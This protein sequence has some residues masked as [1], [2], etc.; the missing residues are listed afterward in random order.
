MTIIDSIS[1]YIKAY[2]T[3]WYVI[4]TGALVTYVF[5]N[6]IN[7]KLLMKKLGAEYPANNETDGYY[8]FQIARDLYVAKR[9]G[10]IN[11]FT[12]DRYALITDPTIP[13]FAFPLLG[14]KVVVTKDPEN[15]KAIL[16]TQFN[17]FALGQRHQQFHPV[18][19]DGI[20]TLDGEG[21]KQS[22]SMLRPQFAREQVGHVQSLEPHIQFLARHIESQKGKSFDIQE[23][24]FRFTLDASTEFLFGES[25][26]SLQT[27]E[28][29]A[30][31]PDS[32]DG[33]EEFTE[34]F[35]VVQVYLANRALLQGFYWMY[36]TADFRLRTAQVHKFANQYVKLALD[37]SPEELEKKSRDGY[38]FLY[39]LC[40][41]T[42]NHDAI[43]DQLLN[44]LIA[45]RDT[46]AGLLS[47]TYYE[48]ARNP[49]IWA[50]LKAEIYERFGSGEDV[51]LEDITFESLKKCEYLKAVLNESLRMY[52]SVPQNFRV[53][54][55]NTT[56]PRG[57]GKDGMSP[58]LIKKGTNVMY[59]VYAT[60]R[61]ETHYGKDAAV[62]RP[63]R[64]FEPSTK[65]LGWAFLPFNGGPRI[66]LGQQFALTEASYVLVRLAQLF[67]NLASFDS[68]EYPPRK[69]SHLTVSLQYGTNIS[70]TA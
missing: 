40:K 57:G 39:E 37:M 20:F 58:I 61:D 27:E 31:N 21:W 15:M 48:L 2:G 17:D 19:G 8:G 26:G 41:Q 50:K 14:L 28:I 10:T 55:R 47:F 42:R 6:W 63:E 70:L 56:L 24:F 1:P 25:V 38:I 45:G 4:L 13:T 23:L 29:G 16:A 52:P 32:F 34:A 46:T 69:A 9:N 5:F 36:N 59:S 62:Y 7:E 11:D 68:D 3:K 33:K 18:L 12:K 53:A 60:H 22:R 54:T 35:N 49:D 43:R 51:Q 30:Y 44:I 64:W 67:P 66:C 65:K